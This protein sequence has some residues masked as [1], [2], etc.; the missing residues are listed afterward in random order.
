MTIC[1]GETSSIKLLV[2]P[3]QIVITIILRIFSYFR[4]ITQ[5][6]KAALVIA[7]LWL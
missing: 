6:I 4:H 1:D 2:S 7:W 3:S 5:L